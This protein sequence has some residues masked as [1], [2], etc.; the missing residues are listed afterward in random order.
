MAAFMLAGV[1]GLGGRAML[2]SLAVLTTAALA[3]GATGSPQEFAPDENTLLLAHFDDTPRRADYAMGWRDF[4]GSGAGL[5]EGYY[6]QALDTR[7]V[8]FQPD[9][10]TACRNRL[11]YLGYFGLWPHGNIDFAQGTLEFWFQVSP[12]DLKQS[13]PGRQVFFNHWHRPVDHSFQSTNL[14]PDGLDWA[15]H[16]LNEQKIEGSVAFDPPLDPV[17]WH[18]YAM[19]WSAGEFVIYIDGR[20]A[21]ARDM[22]GMHGLALVGAPHHPLVM[23][24]AAIDELRISNVVRYPADFEPRWRDGARPPHAFPGGPSV[25]RYPAMAEPPVAPTVI[26]LPGPGATEELRIGDL[27]LAFDRATGFLL[28]TRL[29]GVRSGEGGHGILV[30]EGLERRLLSP[31]SASGWQRDAEGLAFSQALSDGVRLDQG[32]RA[33]GDAVEWEVRLRNETD[34]ERWLEVLLSLPTAVGA[35]GEYFD[36]SAVQDELS[37]PRR[38]DTYVFSLPFAAAAGTERSLGMGIDPHC[39]LSALVSEWIP[40]A[41]GGAIRQ[42]TRVVLDPRG[43]AALPFRV[44]TAP[45][46]FG[47]LE[48]LDRY[49]R[50]FPD[51]YAQRPD[52]PIYSYMGVCRYFD[53]ETHAFPDLARQ[54]YNGM[55][56]GHGPAHVKGDEWGTERLWNAP[57]DPER[58][59]GKTALRYEEAYGSLENLHAQFTIRSQTAYDTCYTLRRSHYLPN[60][61]ARFV[62]ETIW[63]EGLLG[64][65]PLVSGQYYDPELYYANEFRTSLGEHYQQLTQDIMQA[66]ASWSPGFINDMC[67]TSPMRFADP[68]ARRSPGRAFSRDRGVYVVGALGHADRYRRINGFVDARGFRQ[69]I[70]SD[71]GVVS[72][73]L[74]AHSAAAAMESYILPV[75]TTGP[76]IG[77]RAGRYM[78]GEKPFTVHCE[79]ESDWVSRFLEPDDLTPAEL[80]DYYRFCHEQMLLW[81]L[82]YGVCLP[83][84]VLDGQQTLMER[85]PLVVESIVLGRKTVPGARIAEPLFVVRSGEGLE[86]FL[87]V[88]NEEPRPVSAPLEV[89]DRVLGGRLVFAACSGGK[90]RHRMAD[91]YTTLGP[92]TVGARSV[93]GYKTLGRLVGDGSARVTSRLTGDGIALTARL[94][95]AAERP[96]RLELGSISAIYEVRGVLRDGLPV[97][98]QE[99]V[100]LPAGGAAV[101]VRY[102]CRPLAF[103]AEDWEAVELLR[104]GRTNVRLVAG[105]GSAFDRGTAGMLNQFLEQYDVEDG[106]LGNLEPA[107]VGDSIEGEYPGWTVVVDSDA[108]VDPA[109]VRIE[110]EARR[111]VVEGRRPGEARR[112]MVVLLRLVDRRYPHIGGLFPLKHYQREPWRAMSLETSQEFFREFADPEFLVK[113]V[114][115]RELEPLYAD[116]NRDFAG[117]YELAGTPYLFEPTYEDNYVYGFE[118]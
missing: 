84:E 18:H 32:L 33:A 54:A 80:R 98:W 56:W 97:A 19:C 48:A 10:A 37:L 68:I 81:A 73:S 5:C 9:F 102:Q 75:D 40:Q 4:A 108:P 99:G 13:Y 14:T 39:D 114:L 118:G 43:E 55:Q 60:W 93:E 3:A 87:A 53:E 2:A 46:E 107:T 20:A 70:W 7:G 41:Q 66:I 51:L 71:G 11:P 25:T 30:W 83:R 27:R 44:V 115:K 94:S 29:G 50:L 111:V 57:K 95:L 88:G 96:L 113:P 103:T 85:N 63:P 82:R 23:N 15:W 117:R 112:A 106:V 89:S 8:Q 22:T 28:R 105:S 35:V 65:D 16:G 104:D 92:V 90:L 76:E 1:L 31:E 72:Y 17:D 24:G 110:R 45:G 109:R 86:G 78:L 77:L 79:K 12:D 64:G 100:S 67:Q 59:D 61:A 91:D 6:G 101:D 116:G 47:V 69:S 26:P 34:R 52:V 58:D 74:L 36:M 38:R 49:Q 42:G 62:I 21:D